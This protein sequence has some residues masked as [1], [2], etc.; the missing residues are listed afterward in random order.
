M[1][2]TPSFS[3]IASIAIAL[4]GCSS[5]VEVEVGSD[6]GSAPHDSGPIDASSP[7]E[8]AGRDSG[9]RADS[10]PGDSGPADSSAP[11]DGDPIPTDSSEEIDACTPPPCAAPPMGCRY[12]GATLCTCGTLVCAPSACEPECG[13]TDYCDLCATAPACR[14]RPADEGRIC[15]AIFMP[16][17]GCDG[18]TY[19]NRCSL[20]SAGIMAMH[21]GPCE[22]LD[23]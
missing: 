5:R 2:S 17:C 6:S 1:T 18:R 8:D 4:I 10:G 9:T 19:S 16:V 3:L 21:E 15:P 14:T 11:R 7:G 12:E 20:G 13:A 23:P 22:A